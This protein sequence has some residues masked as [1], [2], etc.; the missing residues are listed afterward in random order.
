MSNAME[1]QSRILQ[2]IAAEQWAI[3]PEALENIIA[4]AERANESPEAVAARL[5]R[6]LENTRQVEVFDGVAVLPITGP[7]F[8]YANLFSEISGGTSVQVLATDFR[9]ALDDPD[10]AGVVLEIDSPGGTIAGVSEFAEMVASAEKPVVAYISDMGASAAYWIAS[11]AD[12]VVIRDTAR[13]GSVGVVVTVRTDSRAGTLQ[14]VSRQSPRKRLDVSTDD[15][16]AEVQNIVDATAQVFIEAVARYRD[17]TP[18]TVIERFGQGAVLVGAQTIEA[19]MTDRLGALEEIISSL[20]QGDYAMPNQMTRE[21]MEKEHGELVAEIRKEAYADGK[22]SAEVE[23]ERLFERAK[24][25][26]YDEGLV[27]GA[28]A[29]RA[30]IK[31]VEEQLIPGHEALIE[32]LKWDG[33]T[34]GEQAAVQVLKAE[35]TSRENMLGNIRQDAPAQVPNPPAPTVETA[36]D[37]LPVEDRCRAEWDRDPKLRAEFGDLATYVAYRT[38]V[39]A[40]R[41]KILNRRTGTEA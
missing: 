13:A 33:Q 20:R 32:S 4:I 19:G 30:R 12:E 26:G 27:A 36:T 3:L 1:Q 38:N 37:S 18:E 41:V 15:G 23:S 9:A 31:A 39:E 5:G 17:V 7:I 14:I 2:A 8:R 22:K 28:E 21:R 34:T 29:E 11:A 24:A 40:G 25:A 10:I 6:P 16:R 35:R